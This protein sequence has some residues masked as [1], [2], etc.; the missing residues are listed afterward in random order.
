MTQVNQTKVN[1]MIKS[2]FK[3]KTDELVVSTNP[4]NKFTILKGKEK[5]VSL[6]SDKE[7]RINVKQNGYIKDLGS[8]VY[9]Q[10]WPSEGLNCQLTA[11]K[12]E[13]K[14]VLKSLP[15]KGTAQNNSVTVGV[16]NSG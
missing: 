14:L 2:Q 16:G 11:T 13:L 7:L 4:K 6:N 12:T 8:G 3:R 9:I 5:K 15:S 1:F 10:I